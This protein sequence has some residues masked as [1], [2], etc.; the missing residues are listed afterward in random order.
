MSLTV[1]I[2]HNIF[3]GNS[4]P[5]WNIYHYCNALKGCGRRWGASSSKN[6][7]RQRM[8]LAKQNYGLCPLHFWAIFSL[9]NNCIILV[10]YMKPACLRQK[11]FSRQK[12]NKTIGY[13]GITVDFW[14]IKV[15]SFNRTYTWVRKIL[16]HTIVIFIWD[17]QLQSKH[18]YI[19]TKTEPIGTAFAWS[20]SVQS[21]S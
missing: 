18:R 12:E 8:F 10:C 6:R 1:E 15:H 11:M 14:I 13:G 20:L 7:N 5:S 4:E 17:S 9:S 21:S 16:I 3:I 19:Q 2:W